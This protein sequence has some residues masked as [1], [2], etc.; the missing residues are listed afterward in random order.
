[1]PVISADQ[2]RTLGAS[3]FAGLGAPE[4]DARLVADLLVDA[5]LTGFDSHGMIRLPIYARGIKMGAVKPGAE[6]RIIEETPSTAVID[7]GWN[8]GQIVA[9]YAIC[10]P[11]GDH[12]GWNSTPL[13]SVNCCTVPVAMSTLHR[14]SR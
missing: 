11:S 10:R 14:S 7:G 2:L 13:V 12:L 3:I 9:K 1:M 4:D 8:F 6:V 5:N